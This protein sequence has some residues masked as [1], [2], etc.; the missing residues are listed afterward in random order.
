MP[1]EEQKFKEVLEWVAKQKSGFTWGDLR[2]QFKFD[3]Q[4]MSIFQN[5]LRSNMPA[6]ENLVDHIYSS[7]IDPNLLFIT[8]RGSS[9]LST[10]RTQSSVK[11]WYEKPFGI[12]LLGVT[13][14]L[15]SG[16]LLIKF[17]LN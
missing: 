8:N 5:R 14:T 15:I 6:S 4:G 16:Y 12:V 10:I 3:D 2:K 17:G 1:E 11:E 13:I 9:I 7:G